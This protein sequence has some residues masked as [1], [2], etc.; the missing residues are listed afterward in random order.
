M[1]F[2]IQKRIYY[3]DTD[4]QAVVYHSRYIDFFE[5]AR[6]EFIV[7]KN[8]SQNDLLSKYNVMFVVRKCEVEY[9]SPAKLE[10]LININIDSIE[11]KEPY[12]FFNQSITNQE[13]KTLAKGILTAVCVDKEFKLIR[14]IPNT[15]CN[16][17]KLN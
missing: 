1:G 16:L 13:N 15:I 7:S 10:D 11:I 3:C 14:N 17:F 5:Q 6:T 4:A 12:I 2:S 9:K 8:I